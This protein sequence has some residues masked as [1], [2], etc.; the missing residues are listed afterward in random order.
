MR[1]FHLSDLHIG[2]QL[3]YYNL[4]EDQ[5]YILKQIVDAAKEFEPDAVVLAGDIYDKSVPSAEAVAI[6]NRF[7]TELTD[8]RPGMPVMMIAGNHDS[9]QRLDF[10]SDILD[11]Q[12][13]Y[14]AGLPPRREDE[15]LKKVVLN[16]E[17]GDVVFYLLPFVKPGY[18][19]NLFPEEEIESYDKAIRCL[20]QREQIDITKRNVIVSHQFYTTNGKEPERSESEIINVGGL[21]NVDVEAI[22]DFDYA[23]LGHIH[24]G[25]SIGTAKNRYS[26]TM[27]KYSVSEENDEKYLSMVKIGAKGEEV[28]LHK[29]PLRP[30]RDVKRVKGQLAEVLQK[31]ELRQHYVSVTITDEIE[32]YRMREQ[33]EEYFPYLLEVRVE[34]TRTKNSLTDFDEDIKLSSPLETF[35][36]FFAEMQGREMSEQEWKLLGSI[37][38]EAGE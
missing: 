25:Q 17:F 15:H 18:V 32:P 10:A 20:I 36:E 7:L 9:A 16:D 23:A 31:K 14:I 4:K 34:N 2:K 6:L 24:R 11:R 37:M 27:L 19:R 22:A 8:S 12:K 33:L 5:E 30:L 1:F 28:I 21:D 38:E 35:A 3:H 13:I 26:G 29:I